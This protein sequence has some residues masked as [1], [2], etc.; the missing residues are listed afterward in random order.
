VSLRPRPEPLAAGRANRQPS[1]ALR[2]L[3]A[4]NVIRLRTARGLTQLQL[5]ARS[6]LTN[7]YI[8]KV[9]QGHR[10]VGLGCLEALALGLDC[11]PAD[12]LIPLPARESSV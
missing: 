12:L 10:N 2:Q 8:S 1:A 5:A 9:E 7:G 6:G 4:D 3:L 11:W